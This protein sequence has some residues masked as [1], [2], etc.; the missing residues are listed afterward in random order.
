M[1]CVPRERPKKLSLQPKV[2]LLS[3]G[4]A[5]TGG[6]IDVGDLPPEVT[7]MFRSLLP[8]RTMS[9]VCTDHRRP[10]GCPWSVMQPKALLMSESCVDTKGY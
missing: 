3:K 1:M 6:R 7:V 8:P 10:C 4:H 2:V 5:A 9:E